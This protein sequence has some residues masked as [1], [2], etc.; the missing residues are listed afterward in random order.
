MSSDSCSQRLHKGNCS[1]LLKP[2]ALAVLALGC[3]LE[4]IKV[5]LSYSKQDS[6][7]ASVNTTL[8]ATGVGA[9]TS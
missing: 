5:V 4:M 2:I 7:I 8:M 9:G 3:I 6:S 1:L